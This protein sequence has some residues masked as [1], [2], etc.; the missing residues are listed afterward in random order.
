VIVRQGQAKRL[1]F[2]LVPSCNDVQPGAAIADMVNGGDLLCHHHGVIGSRVDGGKNR[3]VLCGGQ[4]SGRPGHGLKHAAMKIGFAAITDPARDRQHEINARV[5]EQMAQ[6][7]IVFPGIV[8][9]F[10]DL[11]HTHSR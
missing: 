7:K 5:I 8:P 4:Q 9:T 6:R 2:G 10:L 11:G 3:D 1:V